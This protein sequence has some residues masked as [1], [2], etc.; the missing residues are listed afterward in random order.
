MMRTI[1]EHALSVNWEEVMSWTREVAAGVGLL[2]FVVSS[3]LLVGQ[4]A[5]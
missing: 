5:A 3:F 4:L 1:E 2:V